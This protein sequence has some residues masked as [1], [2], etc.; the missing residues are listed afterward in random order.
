MQRGL[1]DVISS[2]SPSSLSLA[3]MTDSR[4]DAQTQIP[5]MPSPFSLSKSELTEHEDVEQADHR[6]AR[7][8]R[9][10]SSS[11]PIATHS[12]ATM[13]GGQLFWLSLY[14]LSNLSLTLYNKFVL[15][16]FPFPYTL[17][18]LHAL[19]GSIGGYI[20]MERGTFEPRAL[21]LSEN[22]VLVAFSV[23]YTVNIAV[24]NLSLGLVTVP[25]RL[26]SIIS[27]GK[28]SDD[29]LLLPW[30]SW[31][32]DADAEASRQILVPPGRKGCYAHFCHGDLVH[33]PK[34][35]V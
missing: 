12:A 21:S 31:E 34:R 9:S 17:T 32:L 4:H 7:H 16:R 27:S 11:P 2:W 15:V 22:A 20:L 23:L 25:V 24:S 19:C 28:R 3:W 6:T 14:F 29:D 33:L 26:S 18:A 30:H 10:Q 13:S 5:L 1:R 8:T 35:T